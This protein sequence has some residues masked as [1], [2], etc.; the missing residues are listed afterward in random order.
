MC[1]NNNYWTW[2]FYLP[3]K[4][5]LLTIRTYP[6]S[7]G[8]TRSAS[9]QLINH[10]IMPRSSSSWYQSNW[11]GNPL[12]LAPACLSRNDAVW[13]HPRRTRVNCPKSVVYLLN[14]RTRHDVKNEKVLMSAPVLAK[15]VKP[16]VC[17]EY[18]LLWVDGNLLNWHFL[19]QSLHAYAPL[20][21]HTCLGP[22]PLRPEKV[23]D[24]YLVLF[25][26]FTYRRGWEVFARL[27]PTQ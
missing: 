3:I 23:K 24:Y 26:T 6:Y 13:R 5:L 9:R 4:Q 12:S 20:L 8:T 18:L 11:I 10:I 21:R 27:E 7:N 16:T 25:D 14:D 22:F 2:R 1:C 19:W 17:P 15:L